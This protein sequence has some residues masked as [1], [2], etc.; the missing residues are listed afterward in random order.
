MH[1]PTS[2]RRARTTRTAVAAL[3]AAA[4]CWG[5][6]TVVS[7]QVVDDVAP[8]TLLP[9]QLAVSCAFLL[10]VALRPARTA[11]LD[12]AG[13]PTRRTRG[14]QPRHRLRA[15]P[16]R[17]DD[18]HG[19]PVCPAVG[20]RTGRHP[21]AGH[22]HPPRTRSARA[23]G[24][25]R[26]RDLR[27]AARAVPARRQRR[28]RRHHAHPDLHR[29]LRPLHGAHPAPD[30]QR[31][32]A[33]RRTCS[34]GSRVGVR[35]RRGVGRRASRRPRLGPR[36]AEYRHLAGRR[37][38]RHLVLRRSDSSSTWSGCGTSRRPTRARSYRSSRYSGSRGATWSG[39]GSSRG[40]G[41]GQS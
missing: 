15:G 22:A 20:P 24:H 28:R 2:D 31:L 27:G 9:V 3:V 5:I 34:A 25:G 6:G 4:G 30:A 32:V 26:R 37:G 19:Q 16:D 23:R 13:A 29:V 12:A 33:D 39:S 1:I 11:G 7:K 18:H 41:S 35:G 8:L 36:R 21:A 17:A 40:S 10:I 14:T 38:L